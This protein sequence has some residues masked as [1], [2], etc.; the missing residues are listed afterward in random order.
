MECK[1]LERGKKAG[2]ISICNAS[3][4]MMIPSIYEMVNFCTKEEHLGCPIL[5]EHSDRKHK[6]KGAEMIDAWA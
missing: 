5:L 1:Y 6:M 4:A 3:A 2:H